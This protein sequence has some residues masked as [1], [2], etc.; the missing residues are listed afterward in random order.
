[1]EEKMK[2]LLRKSA[3]CLIV[4]SLL[5]A[6]FSIHNLSANAETEISEGAKILKEKY[7]SI[8]RMEGIEEDKELVENRMESKENYKKVLK[9]VQKKDD[10]YNRH[11]SGS[12]LNDDQELVILT[13]GN[14]GKLKQSIEKECG[15]DEVILKKVDFS[16]NDIK[17]VY[18]EMTEHIGKL[19]FVKATYIDEINN[20]VVVCLDKYDKEKMDIIRSLVKEPEMIKFK[21]ESGVEESAGKNVYPGQKISIG[22]YDYSMGFRAYYESGN[23]N[24]KGFV[25]AGHNTS[26]GAKVYVYTSNGNRVQVGVVKYRKFSGKTDACFV[27]LTGDNTASRKVY[28]NSDS[29]TDKAVGVNLCKD[30][31]VIPEVGDIV[32]KAGATTYLTSGKILSVNYSVNYDGVVIKDLILTSC[33]AGKGDSG[34]VLY[35]KYAGA[36]EQLGVQSGVLVDSQVGNKNKYKKS[37]FTSADKITNLDWGKNGIW[38]Y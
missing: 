36:Y 8:N 18:D 29:N 14:D 17:K 1:M 34:G 12:Y 25:T 9:K 31:L 10:T 22:N 24:V 23:G 35:E 26:V 16:Y 15:E 2:N 32:Y 5:A 37:L 38:I 21:L 19:N 33:T 27:A 30:C 20:S 13:C 4:F 3:T 11:Y 28:Y 7:E 6:S